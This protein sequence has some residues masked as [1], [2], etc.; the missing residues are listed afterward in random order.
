MAS[1]PLP[2]TLQAPP[3]VPSLPKES[4]TLAHYLRTFSLW[5][6]HGFAD[7]MS[8]TTAVPGILIQA[9]DV[10]TGDVGT[11]NRVYL[12]EVTNAGGAPAIVLTPVP[13]GLGRP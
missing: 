13:A 4:D 7:K 11:A 8:A 2:R 6:R 5:C 9:K 10:Q 1:S 12:L 3:E